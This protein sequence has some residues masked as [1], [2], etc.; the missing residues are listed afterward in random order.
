MNLIRTSVHL[1]LIASTL[2]LAANAAT[3][4]LNADLKTSSEVPV[5]SGAGH[6]TL[7]ATFDTDSN[8]LQYHVT[9]ADLSGPAV[10]AHFHG[11]A[12]PGANAGPQVPV[13]KPLAT[14]IDGKATLTADQAKQLLDGKWYFNVH[15]AANPGGEIRGQVTKQ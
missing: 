14:P 9:Y 5:K 8:L 4:T 11:P 1:A 3:V 15:T 10:A 2:T 7:E 12:E 13:S 6:G